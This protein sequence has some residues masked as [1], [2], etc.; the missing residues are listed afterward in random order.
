MS[1]FSRLTGRDA[2]R[3][4]LAKFQATPQVKA[5]QANE[6]D[7]AGLGGRYNTALDEAGKGGGYED[8]FNRT[9]GATIRNALPAFRNGLQMTREN[10][11]RRG[12]STGDYGTSAEGDLASAWDRN[13]SNALAGQSLNAYEDNQNRY[14]DLLTGGMDRATAE[15]NAK[16]KNKGNLYGGIGAIGGFL[17]SGGNPAGAQAGYSIGQGVGGYF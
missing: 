4:S 13:L 11:I 7:P 12:V 2:A 6:L 14:L 3:N 8:A 1:W 15:Q 5:A 10:A 9:A 16:K 17:L